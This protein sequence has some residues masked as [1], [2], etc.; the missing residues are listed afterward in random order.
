MRARVSWV[1]ARGFGWSMRACICM[2]VGMLVQNCQHSRIFGPG[3]CV[4]ARIYERRG[5]HRKGWGRFQC[6]CR[7]GCRCDHREH[8]NA[9]AHMEIDIGCSQP[10][11]GWALNFTVSGELFARL[12]LRS[13]NWF[14]MR[15]R[16]RILYVCLHKSRLHRVR[17][18]RPTECRAPATQLGFTTSADTR[19]RV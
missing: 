5:G 11:C 16:I 4:C 1:Y 3:V 13:P 2:F 15:A 8:A 14:G 7:G 10:I 12:Q 17:K 19:T 6:R 9:H 18:F